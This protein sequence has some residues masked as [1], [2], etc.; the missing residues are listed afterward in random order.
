MATQATLT[1]EGPRIVA[2]T[3]VAAKPGFK[4]K[5]KLIRRVDVDRSQTYRRSFQGAFVALNLW[6]G[7]EFYFWVRQFEVRVIDTR[8]HRPAGVEGWLPIAGLMNLKYWLW[9]G[10]DRSSAPGGVLPAAD[11]SSHVVSIPEGILQL[12]LPGGNAFGIFVASR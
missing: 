3:A 6:L 1:E 10:E 12:A 4:P 7:V 5:K 11:I 9:G 2:K 8:F